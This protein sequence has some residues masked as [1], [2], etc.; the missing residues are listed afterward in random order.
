MEIIKY[1]CPIILFVFSVLAVFYACIILSSEHHK[2]TENKLLVV[3]CISSADRH[4]VG[5]SLPCN[6]YDRNDFVFNYRSDVNFVFVR[7]PQ[8]LDEV[9]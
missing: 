6:R 5:L 9:L 8:M 7:Y 2:E 1:V 3:F 4:G